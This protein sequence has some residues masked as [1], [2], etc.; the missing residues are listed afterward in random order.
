MDG[1]RKV[2]G[3]VKPTLWR[4]TRAIRN[5]LALHSL[6]YRTN[7]VGGVDIYTTTKVVFSFGRYV[8]NDGVLAMLRA[9]F[10]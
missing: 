5:F 3:K 10:T 9:R 8:S 1:G 6:R 2:T 7:K 4:P